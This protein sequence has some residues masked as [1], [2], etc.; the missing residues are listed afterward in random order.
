M[1]VV[2]TCLNRRILMFQWNDIFKKLIKCLC[3]QTSGNV[4]KPLMVSSVYI[5][6]HLRGPDWALLCTK[7]M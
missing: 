7:T 2:L 3:P 6:K 1:F 5:F 4:I